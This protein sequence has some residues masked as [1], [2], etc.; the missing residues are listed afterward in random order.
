MM[1]NWLECFPVVLE[2]LSEHPEITAIVQ[3]IVGGWTFETRHKHL[4]GGHILAPVA[5]NLEILGLLWWLVENK[6]SCWIENGDKT[7][8]CL[9]I[10]AVQE[11]NH[12]LVVYDIDWWVY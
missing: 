8:E 10:A 11:V 2:A 9:E 7:V 6:V 1:A 5:H 12:T 4:G 3:A